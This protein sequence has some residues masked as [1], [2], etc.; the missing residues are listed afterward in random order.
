MKLPDKMIFLDIDGVL[1]SR[2]FY[3][4]RQSMTDDNFNLSDD[5][6]EPFEM[7]EL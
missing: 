7:K 6:I 3:H 1:N 2:T 4:A 5:R